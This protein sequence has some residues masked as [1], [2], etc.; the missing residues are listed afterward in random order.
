MIGL[1]VDG[2]KAVARVQAKGHDV[3]KVPFVKQ[4]GEW[5]LNGG[6]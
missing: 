5:K 2:N 6:F 3:Y 4:G 1:K